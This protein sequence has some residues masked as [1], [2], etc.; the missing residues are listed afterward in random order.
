MKPRKP[1]NIGS[2]AMIYVDQAKLSD[3][4]GQEIADINIWISNDPKFLR[5]IGKWAFKAADYFEAKRA[6]EQAYEDKAE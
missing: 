5:K 6:S 3:T 2:D 1:K 4:H